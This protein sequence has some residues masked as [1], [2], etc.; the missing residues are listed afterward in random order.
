MLRDKTELAN[1]I[2]FK[3]INYLYRK[4]EEINDESFIYKR[5]TEE[6]IAD[7]NVSSATVAKMIQFAIDKKILHSKEKVGVKTIY[8]VDIKKAKSML[9]DLCKDQAEVTHEN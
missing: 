6:V 7:L 3:I 9:I 8:Q 1:N 4:A 2:K 5:T